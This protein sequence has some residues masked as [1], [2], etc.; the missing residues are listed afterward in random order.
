MGIAGTNREGMRKY[1]RFVG[2]PEGSKKHI[3]RLGVRNALQAPISGSHW[4]TSRDPFA[5]MVSELQTP[6]SPIRHAMSR[7]GRDFSLILSEMA[8]QTR[9]FCRSPNKGGS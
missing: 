4:P 9:H 7:N 3:D 1:R 8:R 2:N 6:S 5:R